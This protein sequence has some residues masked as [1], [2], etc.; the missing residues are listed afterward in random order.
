MTNTQLFELIWTTWSFKEITLDI[1]TRLSQ[2][3]MDSNFRKK[4]TSVA[5]Q[6]DILRLKLFKIL[7]ELS[8]FKIIL[9]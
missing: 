6:L 2:V 7:K 4:Q 3:N 8:I 9:K 1:K 5:R